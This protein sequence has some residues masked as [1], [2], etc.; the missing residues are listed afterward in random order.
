M[1]MYIHVR[2]YNRDPYA[3]YTRDPYATYTRDPYATYIRDPYA[4]YTRD[5]YA[6][7]TRDPYATY[8]RD[9]YATYTRDPYAW[10]L[11]K[12]WHPCDHILSRREGTVTSGDSTHAHRK[13]LTQLPSSLLLNILSS[14]TNSSIT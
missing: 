9:P 13:I 2:T 6:T 8:T 14:G 4:T 11:M 1:Y 3:T 10:R 12:V 5:P 7:Y